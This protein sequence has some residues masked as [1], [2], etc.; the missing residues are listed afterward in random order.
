MYDSDL[1]IKQ[2]LVIFID[3]FCI[4]K[5]NIVKYNQVIF[6]FLENIGFNLVNGNNI[7]IAFILFVI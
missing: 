6:K 2:L 1:F 5:G 3:F 4:G 7:M